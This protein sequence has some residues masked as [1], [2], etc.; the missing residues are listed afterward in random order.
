M[1]HA[2][3]WKVLHPCNGERELLIHVTVTRHART[4]VGIP[5]DMQFDSAMRNRLFPVFSNTRASFF[6]RSS[7][8]F[9]SSCES[10]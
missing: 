7:T 9:S 1:E 2:K 10:R 3:G 6:S 4:K 5:S 8:T